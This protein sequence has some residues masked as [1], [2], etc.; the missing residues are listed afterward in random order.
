[1]IRQLVFLPLLLAMMFFPEV[2]AQTDVHNVRLRGQLQNMGSRDVTLSPDDAVSML[3]SSRDI[4]IH[5]DEQGRFDTLLTLHKPAYFNLHRNTLYLSPGDNME[6]RVGQNQ[7]RAQFMGKGAVANTYMKGRLFP[8]AGSYLNGGG[9]LRDD[10]TQFHAFVDSMVDDRRKQLS[11]LTE[12]SPEFYDMERARIDADILNTYINYPSLA[13]TY[14]RYRKTDMTREKIPAFYESLAEE[15][16]PLIN[17]INNDK[18]LD[19][20]V[21]REVLLDLLENNRLKAWVC[22]MTFSPRLQALSKATRWARQLQRQNDRKTVEEAL[23][24]TNNLHERD[25]SQELRIRI[26]KALRIGKGR[27]AADIQL[28]APDG[29]LHYLSEYKGKVIFLD[30]WATWCGPC[31]KEAPHFQKL[32]TRFSSDDVV[33]IQVSIDTNI[34]TWK[35]YLKSHPNTLPQYIS[36]DIVLKEQWGIT[37]IPRFILID[38]D[39][40]IESSYAPNPSNQETVRLITQTLSR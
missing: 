33:F 36:T 29:S 10:F 35:N 5:T 28:T 17:H 12:I 20:A 2:A 9:N 32:S 38:R 7:L 21:V 4:T 11:E 37:E 3:G 14:S 27:A 40:I 26:D 23:A 24:F 13:L 25:F 15:V 8:K 22:A 39:F 16:R 6:I 31:I 19:V 30:F 1:M 18:Y 34:K